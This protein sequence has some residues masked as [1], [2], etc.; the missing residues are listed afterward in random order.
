MF[1]NERER[2]WEA[3]L[4]VSFRGSKSRNKVSVGEPAEGS[5]PIG[6]PAFLCALYLP[7]ERDSGGWGFAWFS[8]ERGGNQSRALPSS[9]APY[10]FFF[11]ASY[12]FFFSE[13]N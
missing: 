1:S 5:L 8:L 13:K 4:T 2:Y 7:S 6:F 3:N 9:L 10:Q 11:R 12:C